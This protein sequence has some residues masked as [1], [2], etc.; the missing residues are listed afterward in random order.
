MSGQPAELVEPTKELA[1]EW[2]ELAMR[3]DCSPFSYP[4]WILAWSR[5][6]AP[7]R[8][9]LVTIRRGGRLTGVLPLVRLR[10]VLAS[11]TNWHTP[12]FG[13]LAEDDGALADLARAALDEAKIRVDVSFIE[14]GSTFLEACGQLTA[15]GRCKAVIRPLQRSP[16]LETTGTWSQYESRFTSKMRNKQR[17]LRRRLD[18]LGAVSIDVADGRTDLQD[19]VMEGLRVEA[20]GSVKKTPILADT[21]TAG[22]Y[23]AVAN[24]AAERGWLRLWF[25]RIDGRAVAFGYGFEQGGRY[26]DIK[27]GFDPE[28]RKYGPGRILLQA[29]IKHAFETSLNRFEFLG[30][31]DP[32][33][34]EW[35]DTL[36]E[37]NRAQLFRRN[38]AGS[39]DYLVWR[40]G[41]PLVK[42]LTGGA[43]AD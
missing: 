21:R 38:P 39:T 40:W 11:P 5:S 12:R 3:T 23:K 8:L 26:Y 33:K 9:A 29:K 17:R 35:T 43:S 4:G 15:S 19:L 14:S 2:E 24:W 34:L 18:E 20:A 28:Y 27:V 36:Q 13:P 7:D 37:L 30:G 32:Y 42:R 31:A 41:R 16:Y 6:F 25:L 1:G 10:G 22:F